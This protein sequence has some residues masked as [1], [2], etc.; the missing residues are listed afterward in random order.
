MLSTGQYLRY[1]DAALDAYGAICRELGDDHVNARIEEVPG[2]NSA[3]VLVAHVCGVM[4]FWA[5]TTNRDIDVPRD[6]AAEFTAVGTV[7]ESLDLLARARDHLREDVAA[8][9]LAAPPARPVVGDVTIP[10]ETQGDVLMH[11]YEELAQHLGQLEVTR[12]VLLAARP[13]G[14]HRGR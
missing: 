14:G 11:V 13:R 8:A 3:F 5:R 6:R 12:D 2:S 1:C 9:D 10:Y 7:Q 4:A